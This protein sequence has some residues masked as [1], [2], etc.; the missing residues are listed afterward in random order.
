EAVELV[1]FAFQNA[2]AGDIM[3]QKSP[4]STVGDLAQAIKELFHADNEIHI[5]GTRHG[6]KRYETLLTKEEYLVAQDMGDFYR[7]PA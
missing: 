5:I 6:E 2:K 4:A 3:V 7:V 1:V